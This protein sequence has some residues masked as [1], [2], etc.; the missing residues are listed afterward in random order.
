MPIISSMNFGCQSLIHSKDCRQFPPCLAGWGVTS[1]L[2]AV[3]AGIIICKI[4][5][6]VPL[7]LICPSP[8]SIQN[9]GL[10]WEMVE[11][12][13]DFFLKGFLLTATAVRNMSLS[14]KENQ[15]KNQHTKTLNTLVLHTRLIL[16]RQGV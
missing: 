1:E 11:A 13:I 4:A 6:F 7:I 16:L 9:N 8:D 5:H 14:Q 3:L 2:N 10:W 15:P 12:V